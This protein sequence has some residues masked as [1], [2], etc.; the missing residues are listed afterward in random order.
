MR[1]SNRNRS[2]IAIIECGITGDVAKGKGRTCPT[3][4][5]RCH[6]S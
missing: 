6:L 4:A 2:D 3:R 5:R 1:H